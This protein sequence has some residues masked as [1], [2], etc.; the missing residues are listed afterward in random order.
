VFNLYET[1]SNLIS[2]SL[3]PGLRSIDSP[4]SFKSRL[5]TTFFWVFFLVA[6]GS[7][8]WHCSEPSTSRFWFVF[9][10]LSALQILY[11]IILRIFLLTHS[12]CI[13]IDGTRNAEIE[14]KHDLMICVDRKCANTERLQ[15]DRSIKFRRRLAVSGGVLRPHSEP[16]QPSSV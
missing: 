1:H 10:D 16:I 2:I 12:Q 14:W 6:H 15:L 3:K 4:G 7:T 9:F 11:C 5:K 13:I 8:T